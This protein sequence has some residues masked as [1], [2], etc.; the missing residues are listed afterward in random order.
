VLVYIFSV[1]QLFSNTTPCRKLLAWPR[2]TTGRTGPPSTLDSV[3]L[4]TAA[5]Q[6]DHWPFLYHQLWRALLQG[7]PSPSHHG[8]TLYNSNAPERRPAPPLKLVEPIFRVALIIVLDR[9]P[10]ATSTEDTYVVGH[11]G[12]LRVHVW[13]RSYALTAQDVARTAAVQLVMYPRRNPS[14]CLPLDPGA[15]IWFELGV[16]SGLESANVDAIETGDSAVRWKRINR[17]NSHEGPIIN[18]DGLELEDGRII[19]IR[20]CFQFG[21]R[22]GAWLGPCELRFWKWFR[23]KIAIAQLRSYSCTTIAD[24]PV[25]MNTKSC[26][27]VDWVGYEH[28][29]RSTDLFAPQRAACLVYTRRWGLRW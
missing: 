17:G 22:V 15:H 19:A 28:L 12:T 11:R 13:L 5:T 10:S 8:I 24:H 29:K 1:S 2:C 23:P 25:A 6:I 21:E 3:E 20:A 14:W 9:D 7:S 16:L 4:S 27:C 26:C 18:I